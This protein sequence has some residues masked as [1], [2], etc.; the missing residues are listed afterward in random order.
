MGKEID[1]ALIV[2]NNFRESQRKTTLDAASIAEFICLRLYNESSAVAL[3]MQQN[4][5]TTEEQA[6]SFCIL[7]VVLSKLQ[8]LLLEMK[9]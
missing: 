8:Y 6:C 7:V 3:S 1:K 5:E 4:Q 2:P 9:L